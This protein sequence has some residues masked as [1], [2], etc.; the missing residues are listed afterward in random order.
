MASP[1]YVD[2]L[3]ALLQDAEE[4]EAAH[5]RL[6]TGKAGRQW[7]LG[8]LNRGVVVLSVSAW[9]A[10]IEELVKVSLEAIRPAAPPMGIW[11]ALNASARGQVGRFNTPNPDNVR[12]LLLEA[13]GLQDVTTG[14]HWKGADSTRA[15]E[16]LAEALQKRHQIAHGVN[17]RPT[18][19]NQYAKRLPAFFK[20][21]GKCT[22]AIVREHL[23]Q[24]L[25][26]PDPWPA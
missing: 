9:E 24:T 18:I 26:V 6:R 5:K 16:R 8:A 15:C 12:T 3:E 17:P 14:W 13:L 1:A 19:H 10:Y 22:D 20:R 4:L 7:K 25:G 11:P 2:Y 23:V 21:L